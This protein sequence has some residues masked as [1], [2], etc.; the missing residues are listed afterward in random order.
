MA[1]SYFFYD[2]ETSGLDPKEARVMQF[3][4]IR[5]DLNLKKISDTYDYLIKITLDVVPSPDA[6]LITG[7]TPQMTITDGLSESEFLKIFNEQIAT[8][9]TMF[10]GYNN[11][12]FDDEFIRYMNYRNFYDPYEWQYKNDKSRWDLLDVIRMTR[13]LRPEGISWPTNSDNKGTNRLT[14]I[15]KANKIKHDNAHS[16]I[17]DVEALIE[18]A[19]LIKTKQPKLFSYLSGVMPQK[20]EIIKLL[21]TNQPLVY[22]FGGYPDQYQKTTV[23]I[24]LFSLDDGSYLVYDLRQDPEKFNKYTTQEIKK[25]IEDRNIEE[26]TFPIYIIKPNRCPAIAPVSVLDDKAQE[27]ISLNSE[28]YLGHLELLNKYRQKI[29][30]KVEPLYTKP[31]LYDKATNVDAM[32]Y[33]GFLDNSDSQKLSEVRQTK[34]DSLSSSNFNF[35]DK[36]LNMLISL[37]K[38]RNFPKMLSD[39][40]VVEYEKY[41][42]KVLFEGG[43]NSKFNR[44]LKRI[45]QL[46]S[47][48]LPPNKQYILEELKL[49]AESIYPSDL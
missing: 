14:D 48:N 36:R 39:E 37:Y 29:I 43:E 47:E 7:I 26:V 6:I 38:A 3:A 5:T 30:E 13:A 28:K 49:Y 12:H 23:I 2:V 40:E 46:S 4:G 31:K 11:V 16:A 19:G 18:V 21:N 22:T 17:A 35:K 27:N 34:P 25:I 9:G 8:D 20:N 1:Q 24:K 42:Q 44:F 45:G 15:T 10:V 41:R 33:E 32:L